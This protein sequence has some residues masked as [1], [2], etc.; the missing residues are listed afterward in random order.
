M[1]DN[2]LYPEAFLSR[3]QA[4]LNTEYPDFIKSLDTPAPTS[5]RLN[6]GK[7]SDA[8]VE[9]D[10][11]PWCNEGKYLAERP[12]FT[13][14]PLFHAGAYYVQEA[15]SMFLEEVWK[16]VNPENIPVRVLDLCAAPGG[17]STH[18]L[19][20]MSDDSLLVSNELIQARNK[21]LQQNILKWGNA[22]CIVTQNKPD[23]FTAL[24]DYFDV[25]LIDAPCSGEGLFRKDKDAITEWSEKNVAMCAFR[26]KEILTSAMLCLKPGAF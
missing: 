21:V 5:I 26:Q 8:F 7:V 1:A 20:L 3:M 25:I 15:S 17:K 13:F 2:S 18:L 6:P 24:P 9:T 23:D 22:N 4:L 16:Q 14:D 10:N 11:I 12:S 19:S